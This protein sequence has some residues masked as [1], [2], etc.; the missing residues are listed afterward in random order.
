[1]IPECNRAPVA[2]TVVCRTLR[3]LKRM[4]PPCADRGTLAGGEAASYWYVSF[5]NLHRQDQHCS[6]QA[7]DASG[8]GQ[9]L[10]V[11]LVL[12]QLLGPAV[13]MT[14]STTSPSSSNTRRSTPCAAGCWGSKLRVKLRRAF[15]P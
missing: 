13:Q 4:Y 9:R 14:R 1:M 7:I 8:V 3:M 6:S 2:M 5:A 12:D 15:R 11:G 10:E